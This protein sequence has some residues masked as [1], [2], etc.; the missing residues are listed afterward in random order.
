M[1][2]RRLDAG[3]RHDVVHVECIGNL[4]FWGAEEGN[5]PW[6]RASTHAPQRDGFF[7]Y[8]ACE[9]TADVRMF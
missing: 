6:P 4:V 7:P 3:L 2:R 1:E 5:F 9:S 8:A